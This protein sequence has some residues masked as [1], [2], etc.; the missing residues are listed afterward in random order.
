MSK[1]AFAQSIIDKLKNAIGTSGKDYSSD[2]AGIAMSA[3]ASAITEYL[4]NNT[5]VT[6]NYL[7]TLS[8]T[9]PSPDPVVSDSF[10]IL[11]SCAPTGPS[12][13][14]DSWIKQIEGNIISGFQLAPK[15][16]V[17]IVFP[18]TPFA[19]SGI[20]ISQ[21][22]LKIKHQVSD[23]DPQLKVWEVICGGIMEWIN[24]LAKNMSPGVATRPEGPSTGTATITS[25]T[26][27]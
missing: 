25:I 23:E 9:P 27:T 5:T 18:Q 6:I 13:S 7:G 4:I 8:I 12:D 2:S 20:T 24:G 1:T 15:G 19:I 16:T 22:D 3:I 17:G 26:I 10:Q 21:A 11:G 14:F